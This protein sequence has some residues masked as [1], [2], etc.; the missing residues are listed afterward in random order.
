M[1]AR[2]AEAMLAGQT[3]IARK[4]YEELSYTTGLTVRELCSAMF[5]KGT[6]LDVN[7]AEGIVKNL[8][9]EGLVKINAGQITRVRV[10]AEVVDKP[11]PEG[12]P[13]MLDHYRRKPA[14]KQDEPK[15]EPVDAL[16]ALAAV[17]ERAR[18]LGKQLTELSAAIE[19]AALAAED[20]RQKFEAD[21]AR[22]RQLR[23]LLAGAV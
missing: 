8:R 20:Q 16:S 2:K 12:E 3:G 4:V 23:S 10:R 22:L 6:R 18:D 13:L 15:D 14:T 11:K 1:N 19:N 21:A 17:A 5:R 9:D 7:Q